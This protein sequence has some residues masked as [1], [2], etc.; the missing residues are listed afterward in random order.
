MCEDRPRRDTV[1]ALLR[2]VLDRSRRE[3]CARTQSDRSMAGW[4]SAQHTTHSSTHVCT[5]G[6]C[7][8]TVRTVHTVTTVLVSPSSF[9]SIIY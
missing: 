9:Y 7:I 4:P 3:M 6:A 5:S 8:S 2:L 1:D